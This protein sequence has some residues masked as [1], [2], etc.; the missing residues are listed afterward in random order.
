MVLIGIASLNYNISN[1]LN[2]RLPFSYINSVKECGGIPIGIPVINDDNYID[3]ILNVIDGIIIPGGADVNP[4]L[5]NEAVSPFTYGID[6][7]LDSFQINLVRKAL[8]KDLPLLGICRGHQVLNVALSGSLY[9]D[10][11]EYKKDND[12]IHDQLKFNFTEND[13][14]HEVTFANNSVLENLFGKKVCTNSFHH[15]IIKNLGKGLRPIGFTGDGVIEAM[16]SE[17]HRFVL[18]VQWHPER[19]GDKRLIKLFIDKC[20][21]GKS[22]AIQSCRHE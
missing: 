18:S 14:V 15:Q 5:Y 6:D 19:S 4:K 9:Q 10:I 1:K 16:I 13:S 2:M 22:Y 21:E 11:S 20:K 17:N 3:N 12:I 8:D 7:L